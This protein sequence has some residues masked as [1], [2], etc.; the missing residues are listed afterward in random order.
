[1]AK[2]FALTRTVEYADTDMAGIVHH[3]Q[4]FHYMEEAEHAFLRSLGLSVVE[5]NEGTALSWPRV[6]CSFDFKKALFFE[7]EFELKLS[8][9]RIGSTSVTYR[10]EVEKDG[11]LIAVG[12][13]TSVCCEI[14]GPGDMRS[15]PI[16]DRFRSVLETGPMSGTP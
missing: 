9:E 4:F 1:M 15:V 10:V 6:S 3:T 11:D 7:D 14:K 13:S 8:I 5:V 16:P 12:R 2:P